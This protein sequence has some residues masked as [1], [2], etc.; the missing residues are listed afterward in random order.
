[1]TDPLRFS[2]L[3]R[4][5]LG[6]VLRIERQAFPEPWS[7]QVFASELALRRGRAY[8]VARIGREIVGYFGVMF[9]DEEAHITTIAVAPGH[10]GHGLGTAFMLEVVRISLE[11][12]ADSLSLEVATGNER[13]Q[14]LYRRFGL[15]PIGIRKNYYPATGEDAIVMMVHDLSSDRYARRLERI[16]GRLPSTG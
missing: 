15:A 8:R 9:V 5:D 3:R 14:A 10:Q 7:A 6:D 4:R 11:Q 2:K 12:G 16:Q 13:A 1:M